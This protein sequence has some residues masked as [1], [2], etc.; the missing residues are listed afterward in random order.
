MAPRRAIHV[1]AGLLVEGSTV[2]ITRRRADAHQGGKWEFPGGKL[3]RDE[4]PLAGLRRELHEELGIDIEAA[5]P[6][7]Q[8]R[9]SYPECDVLLD[10]WQVARYAG[11]PHGREGQELRWGGIQQLTPDDFP[12]AD[13]PVLRRLQLSS[14]YLISDAGRFGLAPFAARLEHALRA[15]AR[16]LQLREPQLAR[17]PFCG[18]ARELTQLCRRYGARLLVNADP[19]WVA[20]CAADGVHLNSRR[21]MAS[22]DRPLAADGWVAASCHDA[23]QL[24]QAQALHADFAVLGPVFPTASHPGAPVLGWARFAALCMDV[25]LPVYALGGLQSRDLPA[26]RAAGAQGLAM[27][28]GIWGQDDI[29]TAIQTALGQTPPDSAR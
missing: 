17:D 12:E 4:A 23:A 25:S 26:A 27:I 9:H 2:C 3:H 28:S 6:F 15:G 29:E 8:V 16:L 5:Q 7:L 18:Y 20:D 19:G 11:V 10:V 13:R 22:S 1:V 14:L 24:A 21:L